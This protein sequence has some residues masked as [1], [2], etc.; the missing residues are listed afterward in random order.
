MRDFNDAFSRT[1]VVLG[2]LVV[3][4]GCNQMKMQAGTSVF[5]EGA[6]VL[7]DGMD[8]SHWTDKNGNPVKWELV[9]GV[10]KVVPWSGSIITKQKFQDFK[11]HVEFNVP[12]MPPGKKGQKR[13]NSGV[14]LQRRYEV[15]ILDSYGLEP[16]NDGCGALYKTRPPDENACKKP[17]EWQTYDI[18]FH[19]PKFQGEGESIKKVKNARIT[20]IHNGVLIHN[21]VEIPNK[22]GK[23]RPEGPEPEPILLQ[24]HKDPVQ[25]RNIW[26]VPL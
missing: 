15:Q 19:A 5:P 3:V 14:Y 1:M 24:D 10:M 21:N 6:I 17:G 23:G 18:T 20:V 9:N 13:G 2:I 26:I 25:F 7:F 22:T 11:L 8:F 12:Q 4:A 16:M